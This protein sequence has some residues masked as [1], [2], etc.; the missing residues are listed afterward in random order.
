[1]LILFERKIV[2][3]DSMKTIFVLRHNEASGRFAHGMAID[4]HVALA[5]V[6]EAA[7]V[8]VKTSANLVFKQ[9]ETLFFVY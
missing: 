6:G 8:V 4:A 2:N 5:E 9:T 1:M 3:G 7:R